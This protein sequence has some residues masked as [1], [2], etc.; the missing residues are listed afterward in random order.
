MKITDITKTPLSIGKGLLR[1]STDAGVEG[2]AEV[3]GRRNAVFKRLPGQH[4]QA[5][6]HR[7][8]S[9]CRSNVTGRRLLSART[10]GSSRL[11]GW[12][13][14]T[15]DV[16]LWDLMGKET[17]MSVYK[18]MGGAA[19]TEIPLYWSTGSGW[20]MQ[21]EDMLGLVKD[22]WE[23][24]FRAF[25]I[26]MDWRGWRQDIDPEKDYQMFRLAREFLSDG[27]YLGFDANNRVL[28]LDRNPAGATVRSGSGS[29]IS[30]S[31]SRTTTCRA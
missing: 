10:S 25:K 26:R 22:G 16:A 20:R 9:P 14:G 28:R 12:V 21:P 31:R 15:V 4:D 19:R 13:V 23:R 27:S 1:V 24:G 29:I 17:G 7:R 30:R 5:G 3:P 18:L 11:P 2:W 8:G 6:P